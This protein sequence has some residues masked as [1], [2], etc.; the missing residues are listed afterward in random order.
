MLD[1]GCD[2]SAAGLLK[3]SEGKPKY[4]D[5][6]DCTGSGDVDTSRVARREADG[7]LE[8]ITG[9]RLKLGAWAEGI[10]EFRVAAV[11]LFDLVPGSVLRRIKRERKAKFEEEQ[12]AAVTMAQQ[13][14]TVAE[15]SKDKA[16]IK[17]A[18]ATLSQL[19]E[20]MEGYDDSGPVLDLVLFRDP[21]AEA[22]GGWRAVIHTEGIE[23]AGQAGHDLVD[24]S[25]ATPMAPYR[26]MGQVGDLGFG[27][28]LSFCVQVPSESGN[29]TQIVVDAGSHGTHVAGIVAANFDEE[30]A[31]ER[32]GVAPGA[33][34]LA[35]KIGD[36]RLGSAETGTGLV[37]A[38]IA[39]KKA[40]CD[41]INLSCEAPEVGTRV[42]THVPAVPHVPHLCAMSMP[43]Q[44]APTQPRRASLAR[45]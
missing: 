18:E 16:K 36:S 29:L 13:A 43:R 12:H 4:V 32:N 30:G 28:A 2:L 38:L 22:G 37:R 1:T 33:Q 34:I 23:R 3:T 20:A 11:R 7:I 6:L 8:G 26:E 10:D 17:D 21:A 31:A 5:F 19:K 42:H 44:G 45:R 40:G 39:A 35:C 27:T 15:G 25:S 24:M 41:L 9:R 14:L